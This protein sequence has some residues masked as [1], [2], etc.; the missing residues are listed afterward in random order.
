MNSQESIFV[1][2]WSSFCVRAVRHSLHSVDFGRHNSLW[3][4]VNKLGGPKAR[5]YYL[6]LIYFI[7]KNL[8]ACLQEVTSSL[9]LFSVPRWGLQIIKYFSHRH[10]LHLLEQ[11]LYDTACFKIFQVIRKLMLLSFRFH[12]C[13][14]SSVLIRLLGWLKDALWF[15]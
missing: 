6:I 4:E 1:Y 11:G 13:L 2:V 14:L 15:A 5:P 3:S 10:K 7:Y 8:L 12:M 9:R